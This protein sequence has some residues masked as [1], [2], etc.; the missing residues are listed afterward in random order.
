MG[1]LGSLPHPLPSSYSEK[2]SWVFPP[3]QNSLPWKNEGWGEAASWLNKA[4]TPV[5]QKQAVRD[6]SICPARFTR[7]LG[8]ETHSRAEDSFGP[9]SHS[10]A[11]LLLTFLSLSLTSLYPRMN[12]QCQKRPCASKRPERQLCFRGESPWLSLLILPLWSGLE[13][14]SERKTVQY[15]VHTEPLSSIVC[16][17]CDGRG[18][19]ARVKCVRSF[20]HPENIY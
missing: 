2:Q 15:S 8:W 16:S 1:G 17:R 11:I 3:P 4:E 12:V 7:T 19:F 18:S 9:Y 20:I 13:R 10:L 5:C 6:G 14:H